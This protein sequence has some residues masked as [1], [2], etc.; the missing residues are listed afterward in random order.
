MPARTRLAKGVQL[1]APTEAPRA[2]RHESVVFYLLLAMG[3]YAVRRMT[4][5]LFFRP[6]PNP[7]TV[8]YSPHSAYLW[9]VTWSLLA[10]SFGALA[11]SVPG[12]RSP[13]IVRAMFVTALV[14]GLIQTIWFP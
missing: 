13:K 11:W 7:A 8:I 6:E 12:I 3:L 14:L 4:D 5:G 10:A 2:T 1:N 9:R